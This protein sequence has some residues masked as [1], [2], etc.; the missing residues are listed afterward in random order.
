MNRKGI[1]GFTLAELLIVVSI[2]TILVTLGFGYY[3]NYL[4]RARD[5]KRK[6]QIE[7]IRTALEEYRADNP[8]IG[9]PSDP[10][11]LSTLSP[12]YLSNR[13]L[14]D[15]ISS[16]YIFEF[17]RTSDITYW[18]AAYL[19]GGNTDSVTDCSSVGTTLECGN[20]ANGFNFDCNYCIRNP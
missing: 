14:Q 18:M 2:I 17:Y 20:T 9:Y 16:T 3:T 13:D 19:E 6:A 1:L 10:P 15:P 4:K 5:A 12:M 8:I 11:G 7:R